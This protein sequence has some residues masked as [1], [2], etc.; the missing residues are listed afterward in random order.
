MLKFKFDKHQ[1]IAHSVEKIKKETYMGIAYGIGGT[2]NVPPNVIKANNAPP[3]SFQGLFGQLY[4]DESTSPATV[5]IYN[6]SSWQYLQ[7]STSGVLSV[8]NGGTGDSTL[9]DHG[10][11]VGSG[12]DPITALAVGTT[13][14]VLLGATGADPAWTS[15]PTIA[16]TV[17]AGT[18]LV[19]TT[20][21]VTATAGN[22]VA[23]AG[24]ISTTVGSITSATTL[25]AT[26]GN[27]TATNGNIV[28]GTA[29][30]KDVYSSVASTT[31]AGANSAGT[32]TLVGGTATIATTAVTA[33]SIIRLYRQGVG[34]TGAAALGFLTTANIV[35]A[36]SFDI[37]AVQP[38][39]AT[40][41][42]AS[43][44]SVVAWE[45]V[46]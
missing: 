39:D 42:Q 8:A 6:G 9:T 31:A 24:N 12:T 27:I 7:T 25:T 33:S 5:Y 20:G 13:G 19:A 14:Q 1:K 44:V 18:G 23:S 29:G 34:A 41:L 17:T 35:A 40:A 30:N 22:I 10:L 26:L 43:D 28:R 3:S 2:L 21:G 15:S 32:V 37:R 46:N 36:T 11:L 38:A 16:G 45:I 4:I